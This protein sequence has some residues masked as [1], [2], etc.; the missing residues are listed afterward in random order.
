[1][2]RY[3]IQSRIERRIGIVYV[4]S[5]GSVVPYHMYLHL[6]QIVCIR[7]ILF[8]RK[9]CVLYFDRARTCFMLQ[10]PENENAGC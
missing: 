8:A 3:C 4:L 7:F 5:C 6:L 10:V 9:C 1:M 2:R